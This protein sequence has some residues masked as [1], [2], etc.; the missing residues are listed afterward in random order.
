MR[1]DWDKLKYMPLIYERGLRQIKICHF[2][3]YILINLY[4][5][6]SLCGIVILF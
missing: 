1:G 6:I 5:N 3:G 2:R 4:L